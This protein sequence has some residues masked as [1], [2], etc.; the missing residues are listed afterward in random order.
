M[1]VELMLAETSG[2]PVGTTAL[3]NN[4]PLAFLRFVRTVEQSLAATLPLIGNSFAS[5]QGLRLRCHRSAILRQ[6]GLPRYHPN[7]LSYRQAHQI[8]TALFW[9]E[10]CWQ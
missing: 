6:G 5:A 1:F 7:A 2:A 8:Q 10:P 9:L 3:L 4:A